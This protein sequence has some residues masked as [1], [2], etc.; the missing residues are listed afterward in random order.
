MAT[1]ASGLYLRGSGDGEYRD[2]IGTIPGLFEKADAGTWTFGGTFSP[3]AAT[4][5]G[6]GL[7]VG[8][9]LTSN[10]GITVSGSATLTG[11]AAGSLA[12]D[13][14]VTSTSAM[15]V[16]DATDAMDTSSVLSVPN[17]STVTVTLNSDQ[18][19]NELFIAGVAQLPGTYTSGT[20][21]WITG[22][23]TLTVGSAAATPVW[24]DSDGNTAGAG[25][26]TPTGTWGTDSFWSPSADGDATTAAWVA[27][28]TAIFS[29]G[30]DATG[31]F[32]VTVDGTQDLGGLFFEEGDVTL[33]GGTALRLVGDS[34]ASVGT[35]L[36]AEVATP[37][38]EDATARTLRKIGAGELTL[39]GTSDFG[40]LEVRE[41]D[42]VINAAT[43]T[44]SLFFNLSG[45]SSVTGT[46]TLDL[47]GATISNTDNRY[48][49]TI[50]NPI[51]GSPAVETKD[52]GAGNTY[53]GLVFAPASGTQTLGAVLNP[54]NTGDQD[55]AGVTFAGSTSGNSVASINYAGG[56]KYADTNLQSG[57]W[58]IPGGIRTGSLRITGGTFTLGGTVQTD[59]TRLHRHRRHRERRLHD[60]QL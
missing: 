38:T 21:S 44:G 1:T 49:Q 31:S 27:G 10:T 5:S 23:G 14:S 53:L 9:T 50:T 36:T 33:S 19:V 13:V 32:T 52:F 2:D 34:Y 25:G 47:T 11:S 48:N 45:T 51:T 58:S 22:S 39:S 15:L 42:V 6:G 28:G 43:T 57:E 7:I 60:L 37:V 8:G 35:G 54:N 3:N 4:V 56:D 26:T 18:T 16:I 30:T 17:D 55:K 12:S 20:T 24:W 41:G 46:G 29:A 59:Y 40:A